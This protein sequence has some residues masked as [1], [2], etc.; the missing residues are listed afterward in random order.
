MKIFNYVLVLFVCCN[1]K[2]QNIS[3]WRGPNRDGIYK[4]EQLLK[5]W[6]DKGPE[7]LWFNDSI[8]DGYGS[9]SV[10]SGMIFIN[11]RID[12][13]SYLF[14]FDMQGKLI[15]KSPNGIEF[16][17]NGFSVQFSGCRS[18]PTVYDGFVYAC[19][20]NG[21][22]ACFEKLTGKEIWAVEMTRELN[23][24]MNYFGYTESL[25]VDKNNV[26]CLPGGVSNFAV[27]LN[28][29]T[30][31][32]IWAS[33]E[34]N[35][36]ISYCS[37]MLVN[38]P[39]KNV[40]VTFTS[41]FILGFDTYTGELLWS[42]KQ[43][44]F[45]YNQ[46]CNTPVFSEGSLYYIAGEGNGAVKLIISEDGNSV[47]EVWRN[48]MIKNNFCGF[49]K[50]NNYIYSTDQSQK[51]KCIDCN[52]GQTI[53]SISINKGAIIYANG[54]LYCYS[55]NGEVNLIK[56]HE[57]SMAIISKF[58]I[59]KGTR[60]HFANPVISNGILYIRHGRTIM[61]YDIKG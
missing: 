55:Q 47:K 52:T 18:T 7:L 11:G 15:W 4:D 46:E 9:P 49:V 59:D 58:K 20:G 2:A 57:S 32:K 31:K 54:L 6:P 1:I 5:S 12:T 13:V 61:A 60:E 28:R 51:L 53:D 23:G 50:I 29:F 30:G 48:L 25:L 44:N 39:A 34:F 21:R 45:K 17:G 10:T 56:P 19:S 16:N 37:P 41:H 40:L 38:L 8:G 26:Y 42:Q 3:Q 27:A 14:A 33:K 35:D 24:F 22:I 36:T 43:E